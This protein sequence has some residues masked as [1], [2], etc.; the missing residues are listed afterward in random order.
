MT[1][2]LKQYIIPY[3]SALLLLPFLSSCYN[4]DGEEITDGVEKPKPVY[5]N[6]YV[7][8]SVV[9]SSG[10][11][12]VTRAPLGGE[13]GDG[14][15][16]AFLR[17]NEVTGITV[18]FYQNSDGINASESSTPALAYTK[19]DL[20]K[21]YPV[22]LVSRQDQGKTED[23]E[24]IYT[25]GEQRFMQSELDVTKDYHVIVVANANLTDRIHK[26]DELSKIRDDKFDYIYGGTGIGVNASNFVMSS[27]RDYEMKFSTTTPTISGSNPVK[28]VY[29]FDD[30]FIER[31]ASRIDFWTDYKEK[32]N[33]VAKT[34]A[35][36]DVDGYEYKVFKNATETTPTSTDMFKL[37]A[38]V[39]F[40]VSKGNEWL[41]K[42]LSN[43][44]NFAT[45]TTSPSWLADETTANWVLDYYSSAAKTATAHPAF[46]ENTLTDV[47]TLAPDNSSWLRMSDVQLDKYTLG[48]ADNI[49]VGYPHENTLDDNSPIY[50]YATGLAI[51]GYYYPKG[52]KTKEPA[53]YVYYGYL[54]HQEETAGSVSF[55]AVEATG[56]NTTATINSLS[57][58]A[59]NFGV[60]RNNIYRISISRIIE[61]SSMELSIKV[62]KWD[63]YIHDFIY[64]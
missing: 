18:I 48:T 38:V 37:V 14:R 7:E 46:F 12:A 3:L 13:Y 25:T 24:A 26:G 17:E 20:V 4:Y 15:E 60:V 59:M 51:L 44:A 53:Q 61:K 47:L 58:S 5:D 19:I 30:I 34:S 54:R 22:T 43:Q 56:L 21:Y 64:M 8:M 33:Y 1:M 41:L 31:M 52:D 63:P 23:V 45:R 57:G 29:S 42:R 6:T 62:K 10:R 2:S 55:Q 28:A 16:T 9:V 40:N 49:I 27:E 36:Y 35:A 50:Y 39:P 11:D 32:P